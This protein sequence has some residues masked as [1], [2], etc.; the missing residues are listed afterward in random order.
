MRL[1]VLT[2]T[3]VVLDR[4]VFS[5]VADGAD[6]SFCLRPRHADFVAALVPGLLYLQEARGAAGEYLAVDRGIL[7]KQGSDV[8]VS[9][10]AAVGG[11]GLEDLVAVI[12]TRFLALDEQE[13]ALRSALARLESD[14]V[15]RFV[16]L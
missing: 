12:H 4:E 13:R 5:V 3:E 11:V 15:R 10:R 9:V 1:Q 8:L 14:F 6:G 2:P 7:V 16:E